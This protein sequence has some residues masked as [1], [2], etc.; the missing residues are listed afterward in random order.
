MPAG[1]EVTEMSEFTRTWLPS[2]RMHRELRKVAKAWPQ[3]DAKGG[4][5]IGLI[6]Y[7]TW[8]AVQRLQP[9]PWVCLL[10]AG[11]VI[12]GVLCGYTNSYRR[13]FHIQYLVVAESTS[14]TVFPIHN[15]LGAHS[16]PSADNLLEVH[17]AVHFLDRISSKWGRGSQGDHPVSP[18]VVR[19]HLLE[20]AID[21]S[22]ELGFHGWV[23]CQ[24]ETDDIQTWHAM[25]FERHEDGFT[26][27]RMGYFTQL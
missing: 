10:H 14:R 27:R 22:Q 19:Y 18:D 11:D 15:P 13:T 5:A 23:S 9:F 6:L 2:K 26:Y 20:A 12:V 8:S 16:S 21:M 7:E 3:T 1:G 25:G 24:P 4:E 17:R